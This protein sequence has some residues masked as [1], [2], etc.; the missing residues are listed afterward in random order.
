MLPHQTITRTS[1][2]EIKEVIKS[3]GS[4]KAPGIDQIIPK[5]LKELPPKGFVLLTYIFNSIIRLSQWP[6]Q[7]KTAQVITIAKTG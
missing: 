5:M 6:K 4:K 7:L 3:V 2:K 1:P